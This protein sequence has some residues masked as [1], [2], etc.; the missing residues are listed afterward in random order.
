[1]KDVKCLGL[2]G[3]LEGNTVVYDVLMLTT[4]SAHKVGER[5]YIM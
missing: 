1:M 3:G 4:I 5:I 2:D